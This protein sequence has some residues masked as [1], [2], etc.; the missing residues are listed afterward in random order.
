MI[1]IR[2]ITCN[3]V[4][5]HLYQLFLNQINVMHPHKVLNDLGIHKYCCR[6][7]FITNIN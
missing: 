1:P 4:I 2:C 7:T 6:K 5:A 3:K